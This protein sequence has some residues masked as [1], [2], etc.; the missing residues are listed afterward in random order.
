M[1]ACFHCCLTH[2]YSREMDRTP[3]YSCS[4]RGG[5]EQVIGKGRSAC[6]EVYGL[7]DVSLI[8]H[9]ATSGTDE[10]WVPVGLGPVWS[11]C[12]LKGMADLLA[13]TR[14]CHRA[15]V[16]Q[17]LHSWRE[18]CQDVCLSQRLHWL[19][20]CDGHLHR[21]EEVYTVNAFLKPR[22]E[23]MCKFSSDQGNLSAILDF[24]QQVNVSTCSQPC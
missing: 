16:R 18:L 7:L 8:G 23:D 5:P 11:S 10:P 1:H 9:A 14:L 20:L 19:P 15:Q 6:L 24:C 12:L 4:K 22:T 2:S 3:S 21:C 13:Y 17:M